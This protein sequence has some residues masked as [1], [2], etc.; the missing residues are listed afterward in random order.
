MLS[1]LSAEYPPKNSHCLYSS[2]CAT[3]PCAHRTNN[4]ASDSN[5]FMEKPFLSVSRGL[6][7]S[8]QRHVS[9]TKCRKEW[10]V[11]VNSDRAKGLKSVAVGP[12]VQ[13][14]LELVMLIEEVNY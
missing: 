9:E 4:A 8:T 3:A 6:M 2:D 10:S 14:Y 13:Y 5:C 11:T 1:K 12:E 7:G